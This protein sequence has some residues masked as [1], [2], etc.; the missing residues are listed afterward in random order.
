MIRMHTASHPPLALCVELCV[1]AQESFNSKLERISE[2]ARS[3]ARTCEFALE[4]TALPEN[5]TSDDTQNPLPTMDDLRVAN[6]ALKS[7]V[8]SLRQA[9]GLQAGN[10]N[11]GTQ[12]ETGERERL[13]STESG[14]PALLSLLAARLTAFFAK[15]EPSMQACH[16]T[17]GSVV[18]CEGG[19]MT[20][21]TTE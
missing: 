2:Q 10:V 4:R 1:C 6:L 8:E 13:G 5:D 7:E 12:K 9:L 21:T 20:P 11:V 19:I 17:G 18:C 14:G 16:P 3:M 15:H